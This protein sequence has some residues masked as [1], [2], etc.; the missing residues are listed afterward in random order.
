MNDN[1]MTMTSRDMYSTLVHYSQMLYD[2]Y[3]ILCKLEIDG[4]VDSDEYNKTLRQIK[5]ISKIEDVI[6]KTI[7]LDDSTLDDIIGY[8]ECSCDFQQFESA[9]DFGHVS[10]L[11]LNDLG[12]RRLANMRVFNKANDALMDLLEKE[13]DSIDE[14]MSTYSDSSEDYDDISEEEFEIDEYDEDE[15]PDEEHND[16][17]EEFN[18]PVIND[19]TRYIVGQVERFCLPKRDK[20]FLKILDELANDERFVGI[21]NAI[22]KA[23]YD[24]SFLRYRDYSSE[25]EITELT[26]DHLRDQFVVDIDN[27]GKSIYWFNGN[28]LS[29]PLNTRRILL[30]LSM[31]RSEMA[32]LDD[33]AYD[34]L[35]TLID[36][37]RKEYDYDPTTFDFFRGEID[38]Y[39]KDRSRYLGIEYYER[40]Y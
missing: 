20:I 18:V 12:K 24:Y 28:L 27:Y 6:Y 1:E 10:H 38:K 29:D 40:K 34:E 7:G 26:K 33:D 35:I 36:S 11:I 32:F 17:E 3:S 5:V 4:K 13:V 19:Q 15:L 23:K 21:K 2:L 22:I 16:S 37:R 8:T 25:E 30:M 31:I 39:S 14:M 9:N